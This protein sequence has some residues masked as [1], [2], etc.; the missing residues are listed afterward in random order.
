[1]NNLP[2]DWGSK[3]LWK[4]TGVT[5]QE[6]AVIFIHA[7]MITWDLTDYGRFFTALEFI[8]FWTPL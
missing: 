1:M 4:N 7:A 5:F 2:D 8:F 6:E 3:R